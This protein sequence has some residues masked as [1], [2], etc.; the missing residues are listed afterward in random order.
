MRKTENEN[1]DSK[2]IR[3]DVVI[4][5]EIPTRVLEKEGAGER[6]KQKEKKQKK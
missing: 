5:N 6:M 1:K 4:P 2:K 3:L